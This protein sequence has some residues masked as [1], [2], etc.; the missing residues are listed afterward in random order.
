MAETTAYNSIFLDTGQEMQTLLQQKRGE[1]AY[2]VKAN[3]S[4]NR[5]K[6]TASQT[7]GARWF[8][9]F[10]PVGYSMY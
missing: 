6:P 8:Q 10:I 5:Y 3:S 9:N 7:G 4:D 1:A 2:T